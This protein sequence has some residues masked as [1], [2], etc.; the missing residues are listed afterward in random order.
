MHRNEFSCV[1]R[2]TKL[3]KYTALSGAMRLSVILLPAHP[4]FLTHNFVSVMQ[5]F[6]FS[7]SQ[8]A[9]VLQTCH[10]E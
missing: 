7:E 10:E 5:S 1:L 2:S 3:R 4:A 6:Y 9:M 8:D